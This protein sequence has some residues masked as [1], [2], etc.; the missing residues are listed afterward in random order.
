MTTAPSRQQL[1]TLYRQHLSTARSIKSYNFREFYIR[2]A[3]E[4]FRAALIP[5]SD[6]AKRLSES[7]TLLSQ[8]NSGPLKPSEPTKIDLAEFYARATEELNVMRRAA[9][10]NGLYSTDRLVVEA[11]PEQWVV[12]APGGKTADP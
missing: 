1:L 7:A 8:V 11:N 6:E 4:S 10:V 5:E 2:R 9:V 3:R 12:S